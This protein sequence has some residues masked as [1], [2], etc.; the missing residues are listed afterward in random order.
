MHDLVRIEWHDSRGATSRWQHLEDLD[1]G[2]CYMQSVG[3]IVRQTDEFIVL[4]PH[5]SAD[6]EQASG[7][8]YIPRSAIT[9]THHIS[10]KL[11]AV[12]A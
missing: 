7:V 9:M 8:M 11:K 10:R 4:A 3:W 12:A 6:G 1:E 2:A 5:M